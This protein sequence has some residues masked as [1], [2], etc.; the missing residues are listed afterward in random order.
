MTEDEPMRP[1]PLSTRVRGDAAPSVGV[2]TVNYNTR[3]LLARLLFGLRCVL[4]PGMIQAVVVVDNASTHS[5]FIADMEEI[6]HDGAWESFY[7]RR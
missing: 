2:V 7:V 1:W 3:R 6:L 4:A 5:T